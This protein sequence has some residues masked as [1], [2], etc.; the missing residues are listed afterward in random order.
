MKSLIGWPN[1]HSAGDSFVAGSG[2]FRYWSMAH[3]RASVFRL[4]CRS[5]LLVMSRL[6]VLTLISSLQFEC[7]WATEDRQ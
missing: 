2:V 3:C 7:G 1:T 4:P 6:T 5:V